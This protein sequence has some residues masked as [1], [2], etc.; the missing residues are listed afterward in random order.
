M[1]ALLKNEAQETRNSLVTLIDNEHVGIA[2]KNSILA[3]YDH[4]ITQA[5]DNEDI[6]E[7]Y[8]MAIRNLRSNTGVNGHSFGCQ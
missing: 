7:A 8:L 1:S 2:V 6:A 3:K 4:K 5:W